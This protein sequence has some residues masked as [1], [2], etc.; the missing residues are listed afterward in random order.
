ML[1]N[2][3]DGGNGDNHDNDD[4]D[5]ENGNDDNGD[6]DEIIQQGLDN[7]DIPP[8]CL[9]TSDGERTVQKDHA[10]LLL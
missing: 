6:A 3:D 10:E 5:D 8:K 1:G 4:D 9:P 7:R 2:H